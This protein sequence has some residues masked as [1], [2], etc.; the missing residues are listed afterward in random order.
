MTRTLYYVDVAQ[1]KKEIRN[2]VISTLN[3]DGE[4]II[5]IIDDNTFAIAERMV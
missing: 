4:T 3:P 2:Y 5:D 1:V